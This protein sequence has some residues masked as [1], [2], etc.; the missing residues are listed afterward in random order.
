MLCA[1]GESV[2]DL[3]AVSKLIGAGRFSFGS[4]DLLMAYLGVTP[5]AVTL[6][7]LIN[8]PEKRV[9]LLLDQALFAFDLVNF[10]PLRND[11]TTAITPSGMLC[12]IASLGRSPVRLAFDA[13]GQPSVIEPQPGPA[14]IGPTAKTSA[15]D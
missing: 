13:A 14:H 2:I 7:A 4:A 9:N 10:H 5:G 6:F 1:L 11:S 8:D 3:N 12:F 15:Q